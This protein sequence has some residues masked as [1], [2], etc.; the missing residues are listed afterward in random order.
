MYTAAAHVYS[1][2]SMCSFDICTFNAFR[3]DYGSCAVVVVVI[4]VREPLW[5]RLNSRSLSAHFV[6]V[7]GSPGCFIHIKVRL[8]YIYIEWEREGENEGVRQK[9]TDLKL[10]KV[11]FGV[12]L[13]ISLCHCYRLFLCKL[14]YYVWYL[15]LTTRLAGQ[16]TSQTT[17][18]L[19]AC[20]S[21][22]N[23]S[24]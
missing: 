15:I 10:S 8:L 22:V 14:H 5:V 3:F 6:L 19:I 12:F 24:V 1:S 4:F 17:D 23:K 11:A 2:L 16:R 18:S 20:L 9:Y 21:V 13:S 7:A